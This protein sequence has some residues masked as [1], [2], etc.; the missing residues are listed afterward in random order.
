[1]EEVKCSGTYVRAMY[2]DLADYEYSIALSRGF[3]YM[4]MGFHSV[5]F[6]IERDHKTPLA[7]EICKNVLRNFVCIRY[8]RCSNDL[9]HAY[10][11]VMLSL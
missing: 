8:C 7:R 2:I 4:L 6:I 1:M 3:R 5:N 10:I 9:C 11:L